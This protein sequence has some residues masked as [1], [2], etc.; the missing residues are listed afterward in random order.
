MILGF[1]DN[2]QI[3]SFEM[4]FS[5]I[6]LTILKGVHEV[7]MSN[8]IVVIIVSL[9]LGASLSVLHNISKENENG[10]TQQLLLSFI[11]VLFVSVLF[12]LATTGL[13]VFL[14]GALD[15]GKPIGTFFVLFFYTGAIFILGLIYGTLILSAFIVLPVILGFITIYLF[16]NLYY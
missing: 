10:G 7:V 3:I 13:S 6:W 2:L 12:A 11:A 8:K 5:G 15:T 4:E 9:L 16:I 14:D 1:Y